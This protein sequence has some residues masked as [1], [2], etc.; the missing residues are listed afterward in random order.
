METN[1]MFL[2]FIM[3][4]ITFNYFMAKFFFCI[5]GKMMVKMHL[6]IIYFTW[7][8]SFNICVDTNQI[9]DFKWGLRIN[10]INLYWQISDYPCEL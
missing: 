2:S 10:K 4:K 7:I 6:S 8:L 1:K 9:Y 3:L 5:N